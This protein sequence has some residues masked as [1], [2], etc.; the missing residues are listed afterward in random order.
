MATSTS[1][2][3]VPVAPS[4]PLALSAYEQERQKNIEKNKAVLAELVGDARRQLIETHQ[5]VRIYYLFVLGVNLRGVS[6]FEIIKI[7][8][9]KEIPSDITLPLSLF[10]VCVNNIMILRE[11]TANC[12]FCFVFVSGK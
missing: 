2:A 3:L 7:Q 9:Q 12:I 8:A 4:G 6:Y 1:L 5:H 10:W 11:F